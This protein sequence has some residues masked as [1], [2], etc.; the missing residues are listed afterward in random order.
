MSKETE[1]NGKVIVLTGASSGF[2]KG[3]AREFAKAGASLILAARRENL[4]EELAQECQANGGRA[5]AVPT[6]VSDV[7]AVEKLAQTA[8]DEFGRIDVWVNDAGVGAIGPFEEIPLDVHAQVIKTNLLGTI[9]GSHCAL[10][11]FKKQGNGVLI[12]ISSGLGKIPAPYY[13][14]YSASKY[15]IVGLDGTLRQEL[16][17]NDLKDIHVCTVMPMAMDTFFFDH[18]ANYSGHEVQPIPPVYDPQLVVDTIVKLATQPEAE[19]TVGGMGVVM[20]A[21]HNVIPGV[22]EKMMGKE[23]D[24]VQMKN[25]SPAPDSDGSVHEP[26]PEGTEVSAG[27]LQQ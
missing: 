26:L 10:K 13:S 24:T 16:A 18:A 20:A 17:E 2:G 22:I 8:L 5:L 25:S 19:V 3:A 14:S 21:A 7:E 27:R 23:V 12:N 11:Q 9:Y 4:L 6:D 1:L 15:A